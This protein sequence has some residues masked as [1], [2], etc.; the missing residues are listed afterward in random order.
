MINAIMRT[1]YINKLF[2]FEK[3]E[4]ILSLI[5]HGMD[6]VASTPNISKYFLWSFVPLHTF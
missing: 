3:L 2:S 1:N 4:I 6:L 5:L